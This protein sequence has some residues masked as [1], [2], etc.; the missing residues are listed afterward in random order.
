[1]NFKCYPLPRH[2]PLPAFTHLYP[3]VPHGT[4]VVLPV[5]GKSLGQPTEREARPFHY[6]STLSLSQPSLIGL[7]LAQFYSLET[8]KNPK[9]SPPPHN[10]QLEKRKAKWNALSLIFE[11]LFL[12]NFQFLQNSLAFYPR[13]AKFRVSFLFFPFFFSFEEILYH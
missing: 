7:E 11:R 1:M 10:L 12:I 2:I 6:R 8:K 9:D 5:R 4:G 13:T 3:F